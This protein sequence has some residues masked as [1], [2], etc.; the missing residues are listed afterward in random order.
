MHLVS[1]SSSFYL[2]QCLLGLYVAVFPPEFEATSAIGMGH[3][4]PLVYLWIVWCDEKILCHNIMIN[5]KN[6]I[7]YIRWYNHSAQGG[8]RVIKS[9][10]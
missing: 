8:T 10:G 9:M 2:L 3:C 5:I 1:P 7:K 6:Y 4:Q